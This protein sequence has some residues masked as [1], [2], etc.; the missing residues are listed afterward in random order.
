[1]NQ[2]SGPL[3]LDASGAWDA[4]I[5]H[6]LRVPQTNPLTVIFTVRPIRED[7]KSSGPPV[8]ALYRVETAA[9]PD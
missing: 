4:L 6:V 8:S 7:P 3:A 9:R 5:S 2:T 1:M